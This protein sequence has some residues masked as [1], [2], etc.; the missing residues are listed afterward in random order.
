MI[1]WLEEKFKRDPKL[2]WYVVSGILV[3]FC[4]VFYFGF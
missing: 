2:V 3:G 1:E 4:V